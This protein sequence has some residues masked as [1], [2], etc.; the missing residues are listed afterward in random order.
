MYKYQR[1]EMQKC[2][3]SVCTLHESHSKVLHHL[4]GVVKDNDKSAVHA[5]GSFYREL[6]QTS[7]NE[8]ALAA[9]SCRDVQ[10]CI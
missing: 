5:A 9:T 2:L 4:I 10:F 8:V 7:R 3:I 6:K 1:T